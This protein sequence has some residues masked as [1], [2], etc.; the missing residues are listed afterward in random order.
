[1]ASPKM[2]V[3]ECILMLGDK[4][5]SRRRSAAKKLRKLGSPKAGPALVAALTR[6]LQDLRTWETQ[7]QMVMALAESGYREALPVLQQ[8]LSQPVEP[9]VL[10]GVGDA[11]VRLGRASDQ[12]AAPLL[13]LLETGPLPLVEGG[14]RAVAM[15]HLTLT[16][17]AITKLIAF[18]SRPENARVRFW[19]AAA[20]PG[21]GG[22]EVEAFLRECLTD[23]HED[24]R[25]AAEAA[26]KKKYLKW[27]PL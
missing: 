15:L 7:Y 26:L 1:M 18:A 9:M 27:S 25:R 5:S 22:P 10:I 4:T 11:L 3:D 23:E 6:E 19:V 12:D 24:T 17:A 8:I 13:E 20:A 16:H 21:W 14:I 2:E